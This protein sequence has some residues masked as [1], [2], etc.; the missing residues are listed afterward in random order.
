[1]PVFDD[2]S[3]FKEDT[4]RADLMAGFEAFDKGDLTADNALSF[5]LPK[6]PK[7]TERTEGG[8]SGAELGGKSAQHTG[9]VAKPPATGAD[10]TSRDRSRD[11]QG[12]FAKDGGQQPPAEQAKPAASAATTSKPGDKPAEQQPKPQDGASNTPS[13][14]PA[15]SAE[16][17]PQGIGAK[18]QALWATASPETRAYIAETERALARVAEPFQEIFAAAKEINVPWNQYAGNLVKVER[19]LRT[20]PL[21]AMIWIAKQSKVD[22]DELADYAAGVHQQNG[23]GAPNGQQQNANPDFQ[24]AIAPLQQELTQ[25]RSQITQRDQDA[26]TART[27]AVKREIQAFGVKPENEHWPAVETTVYSLLPSIRQSMP[28]ASIPELLKA[29]YDRAVWAIPE[30]RE[31]IQAA[32]RAAEAEK[33][34]HTRSAQLERLTGHRGAPTS[35]QRPLPNGRGDSLRDEIAANWALVDAR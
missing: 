32:A 22:L 11:E 27:E 28:N 8:A 16:P 21:D 18:A 15:A 13:Q 5:Q 6:E 3:E 33:Q 12:R 29:A 2:E 1:M 20:S 10:K 19:Y 25:L 9:D 14:P 7:A 35:E 31:K 17:A 34:R 4:I 23:G 26:Q 24:R 30:V